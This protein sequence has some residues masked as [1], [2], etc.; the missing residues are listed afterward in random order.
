[1]A[2][3]LNGQDSK[4]WA[5]LI[6]KVH[7]NQIQAERTNASNTFSF[8]DLS[9]PLTT[10]DV[11]LLQQQVN[12]LQDEM[13][14]QTNCQE[15]ADLEN[16]VRQL[17]RQLA[18][19]RAR[20][21]EIEKN[22]EPDL[23]ILAVQ[24]ERIK[25]NADHGLET[26]GAALAE[27]MKTIQRS[28]TQFVSQSGDLQ[29]ARPLYMQIKSTLASAEAQADAAEA[30]V[31]LQ[32]DEYADEV[33]VMSAHLE[34]IA[35]M[36]D[37]LETAT[38]QLLA[39]E[40]GVAAVE[41]VHL[42]RQEPLNGILFLT[43]QRLLWEDRVDQFELQIAVP[44]VQ[45]QEVRKESDAASGNDHLIFQFTAGAPLAST[46]FQLSLPLADDWLQMVGRVRS[47]GYSRDRVS[48]ISEEELQ[49]I[50]N[51]PKQCANCGAGFSAP[52]LR[53]QTQVTCEYCGL[54]TRI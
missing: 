51:A 45:V 2:F 22:L 14:L 27:Q 29:K 8:Q 5:A 9:R 46:R 33:E 41:A 42:D 23:M 34:W 11:A 26:L 20:G 13:M 32:Y 31:R 15:L 10:A 49:R 1:M 50:R 18:A 48:P 21:Y 53:G 36:L 16:K 40:C 35:W 52:L 43:D 3:H 19:V 54:V 4:D 44:I 39:T 30:T 37:A 28:L 6:E 47:G 25:N 12:S 17:E 24:W 38:F 7:S